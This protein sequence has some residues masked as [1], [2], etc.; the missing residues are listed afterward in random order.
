MEY[1]YKGNL[2]ALENTSPG[3]EL[4]MLGIS[5]RGPRLLPSPGRMHGTRMH[6]AVTLRFLS[7][8]APLEQTASQST[9]W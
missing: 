7:Q 3:S 1:R 6:T 9:L 8:P 2:S 5:G 4:S